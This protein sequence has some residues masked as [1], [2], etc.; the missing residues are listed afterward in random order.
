MIEIGLLVFSI[1]PLIV[2]LLLL[3]AVN[4][5]GL[6]LGIIVI[7]LTIF[8]EVTLVVFPIWYS[9]FSDFVLE[10]QM[11]LSAKPEDLLVVMI[12]ETAFVCLFG[13]GW[14]IGSRLLR[15]V[16]IRSGVFTSDN[17]FILL[18]LVVGVFIYLRMFS[19]P[20][21]D[22]SAITKHGDIQS[23]TNLFEMVYGW[24]KGFFGFPSVIIACLVI[25]EKSS[26]GLEN[27]L[28]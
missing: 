25:A 26:N 24:V 3:Q 27:I 8:H 21:L 13:I 10:G 20:L 5:S 28:K 22:F 9:V 4:R 1:I 18:V 16:P 7:G 14:L 23:A 19:N 2:L 6:K 12:G 17:R 15:K 11:I